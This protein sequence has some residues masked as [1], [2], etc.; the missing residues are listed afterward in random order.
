MKALPKIALGCGLALTVWLAACGSS[1][2]PG[3]GPAA[4]S[5]GHVFIVIL[6]NEDYSTSFGADSPAPYLAKTLPAQGALLQKYYG[7]GHESNDNYISMISGQSPNPDNQLDCQIYSD[8]AGAPP[9]AALDG[10]AVGVGCVFP[11]TVPSLPDQLVAR[12]L[13]WKGYMEDMGNTPSRESATC[14]HPALNSQDKTQVATAQDE[15]A[16]RHDPF[17]YFHSVIDDQSYCDS[18][19][20]SFNLVD[21]STPLYQDLASVATTPNLVFITPNLC[22]DGHDSPCADGEPGGLVSANLFL[23]TLAPII[24]ASPAFQQDGLLI[25]TFDESGGPQSDSSS[26]CGEVPGP[27]TPL[28]G[29]TGLGGGVIGEVLVSPFIKPGTVSTTAYNHYSMLR[30]IEDL[31][32]LDYIG[33]AGAS[34][35]AS[36]GSDVFTQTMPVLPAKS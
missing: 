16:T 22:H 10:Q 34:G 28:P 23:K 32:G 27:N 15:Y 35:Q 30:S 31:F 20:V 4:T 19:V 12:N 24:M 25:V 6:E 33:N 5:V 26:C 17:M 3:T 9:S 18:H 11:T 2:A 7:T 1:Q 21:A 29:L 14:G 36:F 8:F 13:N